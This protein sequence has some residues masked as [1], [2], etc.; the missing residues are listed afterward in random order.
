MLSDSEGFILHD[1][2]TFNDSR[3]QHFLSDAANMLIC[4]EKRRSKGCLAWP[5]GLRVP[6]LGSNMLF[7]DN[8]LIKPFSFKSLVASWNVMYWIPI[9]EFS[10]CTFWC[11]DVLCWTSS[12]NVKSR[13][14]IYIFFFSF[15][16]FL[17]DK[18][19]ASRKP[20]VSLQTFI[21]LLDF[22]LLFCCFELKVC[23]L[24]YSPVIF[25]PSHRLPFPPPTQSG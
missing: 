17:L 23:V 18:R 10:E 12:S 4:L 7:T 1:L 20:W 14:Q 25:Y 22:P 13:G 24:I 11:S 3:G 15:F 6:S 2:T 19:P 21:H 5:C 16:F 8:F 9:V